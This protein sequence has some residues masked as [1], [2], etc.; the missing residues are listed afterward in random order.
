M[1]PR[2]VHIMLLWKDLRTCFLFQST[3]CLKDCCSASISTGR[4]GICQTHNC[5]DKWSNRNGSCGRVSF[6]APGLTHTWRRERER[7]KREHA[8]PTSTGPKRTDQATREQSGEGGPK[9]LIIH[10]LALLMYL[11]YAQ[12]SISWQL[13]ATPSALHN[14]VPVPAKHR[15]FFG[16]CHWI[17]FM[18]NNF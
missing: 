17:E 9:S 4:V 15:I 10:R 14:W 1:A 2:D 11:Y 16:V 12:G 5:N 18:L 8:Q 3:A 13:S 7:E 6:Q